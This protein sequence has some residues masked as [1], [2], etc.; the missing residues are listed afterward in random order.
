VADKRAAKGLGSVFAEKDGN[1]KTKYVAQRNVVM[2]D[3]TKRRVRARGATQQEALA[4]LNAKA[5]EATQRTSTGHVR[6]DAFLD[7]WLNHKRA[8]VRASTIRAYEQDVRLHI[9][10]ALG[11]KRVDRLEARHVQSMLDALVAAGK[12]NMA[13]R[14]RRTMK[15]ALNAA[16]KWGYAPTNVMDRIDPVRKPDVRRGVYTLEE[17]RLFLRHAEASK[18]YAL[19]LLAFATGMRKGELL[20]LQWQDLTDVGVHVR[21][22]VS[23]GAKGDGTAPPKTSAGY[24]FIPVAADTMQA[25]LEGRTAYAQ[26]GDWVF[27][28]RNGRRLSG[29]NVSTAMRAIQKRYGLPEIR[30]HDF[31]RS[32]A[33]LLAEAGHHPRVI[34]DLLGHA[35]PNLAMLVY[36]DA[37]DRAKA[38][39]YVNLDVGANPSRREAAPAERADVALANAAR[40]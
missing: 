40:D 27:T 24:R 26:D 14:V 13:D 37:T 2:A 9:R 21:R 34:Q 39:A 16:V 6:F 10:P 5:N 36:Q 8:H 28:T 35:T 25:V 22:T 4:K 31:R 11:G 32:Y 18:Y 19:F 17:I 29:R 3:G 23:I 12:H 20:A 1:R 33:T 15:T 7:V 30:F 38:G